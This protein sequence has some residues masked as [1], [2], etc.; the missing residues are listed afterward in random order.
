MSKGSGIPTQPER[1]YGMLCHE[2]AGEG[3]YPSIYVN[4][5]FHLWLAE[6]I[7]S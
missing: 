1:W 4:D 7:V 2:Q 5:E 3:F 6:K